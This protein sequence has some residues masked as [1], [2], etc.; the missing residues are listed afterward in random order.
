MND[1][2]IILSGRTVT[3]TSNITTQGL[4]VN[5]NNGG[6]LNLSTFQFTNSLS[7]LAGQGTL[8]LASF[9]FPAVVANTFLNAG[10]G[11]TEY[12]VCGYLPASPSTYNN[13]TINSACPVIQ[14]YANLP[15]LTLN[16]NLWVENGTFQINDN[17]N[18]EFQ[19]STL[20]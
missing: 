10:G 1:N 15:L 14:S 16:G 6:F 9:S 2:A 12:D 3:L 18:T 17:T 5:I 4:N 19:Y 13:L 7:S 20:H 8:Q 11:T